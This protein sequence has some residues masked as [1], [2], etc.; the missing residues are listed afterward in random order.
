LPQRIVDWMTGGSRPRSLGA[1][2]RWA[3][4]FGVTAL[5]IAISA[6]IDHF[7]DY[8][9]PFQPL[10]VAL[11]VI[12]SWAGAW[13]A[14]A[15]LAIGTLTYLTW[16][17]EPD[18]LPWTTN[19]NA[20][21][22][23][24]GFLLTGFV[25]IGACTLLRNARNRA[26]RAESRLALAQEE[27]GVA[28]WE[29]D[30]RNGRVL[31]S[32]QGWRMH[33]LPPHRGAGT[34][35]EWIGPLNAEDRAAIERR[36]AEGRE[37]RFE[38][39][40][41][42]ATPGAGERW[43]SARIRVHRDERGNAV[44]TSGISLDV[45]EA[46]RLREE[47]SAS[48]QQLR[49][50]A[51]ALPVLIAHV[52][53]DRT[54]RFANA[55]YEGW[56]GIPVGEILG[57]HIADL[58]G[59]DT[60]ETVRPHLDRAF[61][62]D[63]VRYRT[64][65]ESP[66]Y[67][68]RDLA[69]TYVPQITEDGRIEGIVSLIDDV[70]DEVAAAERL[71]ESEERLQLAMDGARMGTWY[72]DSRRDFVIWDRQHFRLLGLDPDRIMKP[73][74][75]TWLERVHPDDRERVLDT[76]RAAQA[77]TRTFD[78]QIRIVRADTGEERWLSMHGR[79]LRADDGGPSV[80]SIGIVFDVTDQ[81]R[82]ELELRR[83]EATYRTLGEAVP[84]LV[85]SS[86]PDGRADYVNRNF[87][88]YTGLT[89]A[90]FQRIGW[91]SLVHPE[92][93]AQVRERWNATNGGE[94]PF[95][96]EFRSRRSD[97]EYR[98]L[99]CR[100]LPLHDAEGR[101]YKWVGF[102]SDVTERR[103]TEEY[104]RR[105]DAALREADK[106]KDE[107]LATL[108][109]ELRNPLAP[110]R[111]AVRLLKPDSPP[112]ALAQGRETIE[113]QATHM[114]RLL[115]D[116]LDMSRI[117]R[118]AIELRR[119]PMDL[120]QAV[121]DSIEVARPMI[122]GVQHR[123]EIALPSSPV[124]IDADATRLAQ[125]V[126]NL[127]Q[128]A[129]KYTDPGGRIEVRVESDADQAVLRI[130]DT[131]IG[132]APDMRERVFELFSQVHRSITNSR[133]GLGIGL[134]IVKRL[135][136]LHGGTIEVRS[137]GLGRGSEFIVRLPRCVLGSQPAADRIVPLPRHDRRRVLVA[138]D[139]ADAVESL[140]TL[141]RLA[142]HSVQIAHDGA[143]AIA[144]AETARPDV[145][146]LDLGMPRLSGF[147]VARWLRRQPWG[148]DIRLIAVTGWG[149]EEDRRRSREAGFDSHLTKPVDPDELL[150]QLAA[151]GA[152]ATRNAG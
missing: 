7:V 119:R 70:T 116:L 9:T 115:D 34:L 58:V 79:F 72:R 77:A 148:A 136:E 82:A 5:A 109:H 25:I 102:A 11:V 66:R 61:R 28:V 114:A 73:T 36:I 111:Y 67:G 121:E 43:L 33:G 3:M 45:T 135:V 96:A 80:R 123:L 53:R 68:L 108:A 141:L 87:T 54:Y 100:A 4:T 47:R 98:W 84:D 29:I 126:G 18:G 147:D 134:A 131:G 140:A 8:G 150:A 22:S 21:V 62:G 88:E 74:D 83:S 40:F 106:R 16:W 132:L 44:R 35:A 69:V 151:L 110:I 112:H 149:Q 145:V 138:D 15:S 127:L 27:V 93:D 14:A 78:M 37:N 51:N 24:L 46:R 113:R 48:E 19:P 81:K 52:D 49:T 99:W 125:I 139:N 1:P 129:A 17:T 107:F 130:A 142:G 39:E 128:N 97:G 71:R 90:Q 59:A 42:V 38:I 95:E 75:A 50:I 101:L 26:S 117:T 57:R 64:R 31:A 152:A 10:Y 122:D 32:D 91:S 104:L 55:A 89:L 56:F 76:L 13:P 120:R 146:V 20:Q 118:G 133:G 65:I 12:A 85:W 2:A 143:A 124:W 60:F 137:E 92:D 6:A 30:L 105:T 144:L 63:T 103:Q 94:A 41:R 23:A 86:G